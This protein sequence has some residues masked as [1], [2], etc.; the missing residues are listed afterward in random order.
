M[1]QHPDGA[2]GDFLPCEENN[3]RQDESNQ[4]MIQKI[5]DDLVKNTN[6]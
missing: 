2:S 5:I 3:D 6:F 4:D 1:D